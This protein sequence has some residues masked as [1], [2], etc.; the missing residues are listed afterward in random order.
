MPL[1]N[2]VTPEGALAADPARGLLMGNRGGRIHDPATRTLGTARWKSKAWICCA[3]SFK[4]RRRTVWGA[5]YTELFFCDEPTALAAGHRPCVECR[6]ADAYAWRD[7]V[8][9]YLG[10]PATP[11]FPELDMRLH[12]ERLDGRAKRRHALEADALPDGVM[13][14]TDAGVLAIRGNT[15]MPWRH[16]G[17]GP[18]LPRPRGIVDVL[19]PPTNLAALSAGFRPMWH[20]SATMPAD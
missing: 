19:T 20:S 11:R 6:R 4:G 5:G 3:L 7:A 13:V 1:R 15:A 12:A 9:R 8:V 16:E 10:L 18:A 14:R 17:Y 2:R